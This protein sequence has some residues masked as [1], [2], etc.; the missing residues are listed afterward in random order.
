MEKVRLL[1]SAASFPENYIA[2]AEAVGAV[3]RAEYAP[4][5]DTGY[6]GLVICGGVDVD[7][8]YY[9]EPI[10]GSE[11]IDKCRDDAE[12]ALLEAYIKAGKPVLGIC[13]G[14]QLINIFFGGSLYQNID[15]TDVHKRHNGIDKVHKITADEDSVIGR[16]YG[17]EFSVNSSHHQAVKRLGKGIKATAWWNDRYAEAIEH[18]ELPVF[19]VQFHP[20][21]MCCGF[22][23][24]NTVDGSKIFEHFVEVCHN[25]KR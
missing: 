14:F 6:D 11:D 5:A 4:S 23:S 10:D 20:E 12:F 8:K 15:E 3:A 16:L 21:R 2:A 25:N 24:E 18:T 9:N 7:P 13:R 1:L 19:A 22:A 17:K